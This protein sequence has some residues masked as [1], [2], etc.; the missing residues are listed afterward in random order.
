[1]GPLVLRLMAGHAPLTDDA[2]SDL[3]DA[4]LHGLVATQDNGED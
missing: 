4:V 1:M 2:A 3:A